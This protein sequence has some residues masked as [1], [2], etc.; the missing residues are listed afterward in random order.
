[1]RSIYVGQVSIPAAVW[2]DGSPLRTVGPAGIA[3]R[4]PRRAAGGVAPGRRYPQTQKNRTAC[5]EAVRS[6]SQLDGL[7]RQPSDVVL[8][9][10]HVDRSQT[11]GSLLDIEF[12]ALVL[13]Q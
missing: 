2:L 11:L 12:D 8:Q 6:L 10:C 4:S 5:G 3:L 7:P 13:A 9:G 1:V